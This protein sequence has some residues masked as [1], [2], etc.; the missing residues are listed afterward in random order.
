M[1]FSSQIVSISAMT[2]SAEESQPFSL[3]GSCGIK[4]YAGT[5]PKSPSARYCGKPSVVVSTERSLPIW[6]FVGE[7]DV[8]VKPEST[9]AFIESVSEQNSDA[10]VTVFEATDHVGVLQRAWLENG[11]ALLNWLLQ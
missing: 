9:E 6:A 5:S 7:D 1:V 3:A 8:V 11:K 4:T 2:V 10:R